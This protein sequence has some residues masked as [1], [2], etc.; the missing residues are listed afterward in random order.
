MKTWN[1][2]ISERLRS[3]VV[4]YRATMR[5]YAMSFRSAIAPDY[6]DGR[7]F[8]RCCAEAISELESAK[9]YRDMA[10]KQASRLAEWEGGAA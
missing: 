4:Q 2:F 5:G 10:R 1:S 7:N 8:G 3:D 6:L 9:F